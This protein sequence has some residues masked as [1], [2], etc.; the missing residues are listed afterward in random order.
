MWRH[1][2]QPVRDGIV[3]FAMS[4]L[5]CGNPSDL[6]TVWKFGVPVNVA[7]ACLSQR[8]CIEFSSSKYNTD[9]ETQIASHMRLCLKINSDNQFIISSSG[10]EPLLAEA[11]ATIMQMDVF[12]AAESLKHVVSGFAINKGDRGELVALLAMT[13]ARDLAIKK[14]TGGI[15]QS[16]RAGVITEGQP[17]HRAVT[18]MEFLS[19]LFSLDSL[20]KPD[21]DRLSQDFKDAYIYFNH[22]IRP[23]DQ[24][25]FTL[26]F[27]MQYMTRG[28]GVLCS[29]NMPGIDAAFGVVFESEKGVVLREDQ[30]SIAA[31]Q[32]KNDFH[33]RRHL[34]GKRIVQSMGSIVR[35]M[36]RGIDRPRPVIRIV[37]SFG[38]TPELFYSTSTID[39]GSGKSV[40]SHDFWCG[41]IGD[42]LLPAD[43]ESKTS[44][45]ALLSSTMKSKELFEERDP[46]FK[47][48]AKERVYLSPGGSQ[49]HSFWQWIEESNDD[50]AESEAEE[51][52]KEGLES[53]DSSFTSVRQLSKVENIG[54]AT[55]QKESPTPSIPAGSKRKRSKI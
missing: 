36:F 54:K 28:A 27:L 1:G 50:V 25:T 52:R 35:E 3:R 47:E 48:F 18:V 7:F 29:T 31:Q 5:I 39:L 43:N 55:N 33:I 13:R 23:F 40:T 41:G 34:H 46:K 53:K 2:D 14:K 22:F 49:K 51:D 45:E 10:S 30:M 9:K 38:S 32:I 19:Q 17:V 20:K 4:K 11:A 44:W 26:R 12:K 24:S 16:K 15:D 21:L 8:L 6:T 42:F 37:F